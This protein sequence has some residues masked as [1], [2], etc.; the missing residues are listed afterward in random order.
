MDKI[1][2]EV[3]DHMPVK[4]TCLFHSKKLHEKEAYWWQR[5]RRLHNKDNQ[6]N[7][8]TP[9]SKRVEAITTLMQERKLI[10]W[11]VLLA[12]YLKNSVKPYRKP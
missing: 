5:S 7:V 6:P 8:A 12:K 2:Q 3:L 4:I 9:K 1:K 11:L 10:Y